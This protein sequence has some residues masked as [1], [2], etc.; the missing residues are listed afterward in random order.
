MLNLAK[1]ISPR[2]I[3]LVPA[4]KYSSIGKDR[5]KALAKKGIIRG[6]SDPDNKRGDWLFDKE[7]IDKYR[8]RQAPQ[9][10]E[11]KLLE[12]KSKRCL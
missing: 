4:V 5:L 3:K 8:L 1:N 6:F 2:W 11:E 9:T 7:S 12:I 10:I